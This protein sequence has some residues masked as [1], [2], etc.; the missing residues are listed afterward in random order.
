MGELE[1]SVCINT[2]ILLTKNVIYNAMKDE[3]KP[4]HTS[5]QKM[6]QRT[7]TFKKNTDYV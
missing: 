4:S 3:K 5:C 7:Y 6:R 2:I 1:N